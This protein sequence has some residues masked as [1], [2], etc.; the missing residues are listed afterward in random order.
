M[1]QTGGGCPLYQVGGLYITATGVMM[2]VWCVADGRTTTHALGELQAR[3]ILFVGPQEDTYNGMLI[4][5]STRDGDMEVRC[6]SDVAATPDVP[7]QATGISA[8]ARFKR[9]TVL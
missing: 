1:R 8:L 2:T 3:G 9:L 6:I 7:C 5:E 4:G